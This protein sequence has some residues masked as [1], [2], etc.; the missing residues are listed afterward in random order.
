MAWDS[1]PEKGSVWW[2]GMPNTDILYEIVWED[3]HGVSQI[4]LRYG[5]KAAEFITELFK[6]GCKLIAVNIKSEIYD[7]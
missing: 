6:I 7:N 4:N 3:A 2:Q 1:A 5:N